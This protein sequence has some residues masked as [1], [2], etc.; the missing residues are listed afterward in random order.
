MAMLDVLNK[1]MFASRFKLP[2]HIVAGI[3]VVIVIG[4]SVPRLFMKNQPRTRAGTI[5]LGMGAKSLILFT[6]ML[7]A[8]H[9]QKFK[10]WHS[11]KANV[12]IS[13][14]EIV[15]WGAVAFLG[16]QSNLKR[17]EGVTCYLSWVTVGIA[18]FINHLEIY[19]S[20]IAIREFR[21]YRKMRDGVPLSSVMSRGA[22]EEEM[23]QRLPPAP[24]MA[25][26]G[27]HEHRHS[28]PPRYHK[29]VVLGK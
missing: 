5:A 17:C 26:H 14:L 13:C 11:Y 12:I 10:R 15:F 24:E 2:L 9:I 16:F 3:L 4:L 28:Q 8:E 25:Y 20:A 7:A 18:V 22:D 1:P 6:Y 21:D 23:V 27:R 19:A 29:Q